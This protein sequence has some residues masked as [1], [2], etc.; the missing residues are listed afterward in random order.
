MPIK[1]DLH[2]HSKYSGDSY[3]Q[4]CT[5]QR[6]FDYAFDKS[7]L[8]V[9]AIT[10]ARADLFFDKVTNK[11]KK[12]FSKNIELL[13]ANKE[14]AVF[15]KY[16][17]RLY[18]LRG[19]EHHD[20]NGGHILQIGGKNPIKYDS[21]RTLKERINYSHDE[22]ALAGIA[23]P[24]Y[25]DFGGVNAKTLEELFSFA[26]FIEVF[27]SA[28]K[29][30]YN[31]MTRDFVRKHN[32]VGLS[33]SDSHDIKA[34]RAYTIFDENLTECL[35]ENTSLIKD[36]I[37]NNKISGHHQEYTGFWEKVYTFALRDFLAGDPKPAIDRVKREIR[38][39]LSIKVRKS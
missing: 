24:Y 28:S 3:I 31:N 29:K 15:K 20:D 1:V 16:G 32:L 10:D 30:E 4:N 27:N 25:T 5:P 36:A 26:D 37:K 11:P 34:G 35:D 17:E 6:I 21:K 2:N 18:L 22:G 14:I 8:D 7:K 33:N 38:N 39:R 9:L 23:H 12:Y 13:D 19:M